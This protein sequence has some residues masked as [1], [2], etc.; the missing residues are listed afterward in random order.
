MHLKGLFSDLCAIS[1]I[2]RKKVRISLKWCW[3]SHDF[4]SGNHIDSIG[5]IKNRHAERL[6]GDYKIFPLASGKI[7]C[8]L[9]AKRDQTFFKFS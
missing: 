1:E 9:K 6:L 2:I 5:R 3:D 8:V 4:V 7:F